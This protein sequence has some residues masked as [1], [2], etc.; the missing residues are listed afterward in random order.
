MSRVEEEPECN[1]K[2]ST[3]DKQLR[4][5]LRG[6]QQDRPRDVVTLGGWIQAGAPHLAPRPG[7][8]SRC[9]SP[10]RAAPRLCPHDVSGAG[11]SRSIKGGAGGGR[12]VFCAPQPSVHALL[13]G[14]RASTPSTA[15]TM[16]EIVHI[17]AGQCGNQIGAK[18]GA[19]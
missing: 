2:V 5:T 9:R 6:S 4:W 8:L 17:Q 12:L 18:V 7:S 19:P 15:G 11:R 1:L 13:R 10:L 14:Q 3:I 16:R